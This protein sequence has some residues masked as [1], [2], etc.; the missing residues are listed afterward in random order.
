MKFIITGSEGFIGKALAAFIKNLGHEVIGVDRRIGIEAG[1][2]FTTHSLEGIDAVFHL[3]AQ[4]SVFNDNRG[5]IIR[6]NIDVFRIVSDACIKQNVPLVYASSSTAEGCNTT[7]LYGISKRFDEEYARCYNTK[8]VGVRFHNVYGP[9]PRNG[10]L[11]WH[12]LNNK[13]V[14]LFNEGRNTR[15]FTYIDDIVFGLWCISQTMV[16]RKIFPSAERNVVNIANPEEMTTRE[17]AEIVRKYKS[18]ELE[19]VAEERGYDR[20]EQRV[21]QGIYTLPLCYTS[22]AEGMKGIFGVSR[23]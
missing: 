8:S 7:S 4:T 5:D 17:F 3:A 23:P 12:L 11:L 22:V 16:E 20:R 18:V 13:S 15:H 10:T 9:D 21:N 19:L 14:R 1:E 6:D 2:Y